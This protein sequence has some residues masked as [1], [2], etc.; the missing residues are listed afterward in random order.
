MRCE[1]ACECRDDRLVKYE[2]RCN[3]FKAYH[4][5]FSLGLSGRYGNNSLK[6]SDFESLFFLAT[7]HVVDSLFIYAPASTMKRI[8]AR[9]PT[10][11]EEMR[12]PL[13][14]TS[15]FKMRFN[16]LFCLRLSSG[17]RRIKA[18]RNLSMSVRAKF[19]ARDCAK[20]AQPFEIA[21]VLGWTRKDNRRETYGRADRPLLRRAGSAMGPLA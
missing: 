2:G 3:S 8:A 9:H 20:K 16:A 15:T 11:Q 12:P 14:L 21:G 17:R 4:G 1:R 10:P 18:K 6:S 5:Y 19:I 13:W 7:H